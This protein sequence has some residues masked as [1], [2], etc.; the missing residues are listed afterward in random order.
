MR[1]NSG[2]QMQYRLCLVVV[3]CVVGILWPCRRLWACDLCALYTAMQVESPQSGTFRASASEQYTFLDKLQRN[4]SYVQNQA[5]EYLKS[6]VTQVAA[7]Y[8]FS[9]SLAL[10]Y[11]LPVISRSF[12]RLKDGS[13]TSGSE[14][15]VGDMSFLLH[16]LPVRYSDGEIT[17]RVRLFAGLKL[18]TGDTS[19][20]G[21]ESHHSMSSTEMS[22][23]SSMASNTRP[24]HSESG[25]G[26]SDHEM[27]THDDEMT[28]SGIHSHDLTLG[29]GSWDFPLG[30][31]ITTQYK[32]FMAMADVQYMIRSEGAYSYRHANDLI[33]STAVGGFLYLDDSLQIAS[34]ARL[35]GQYKNNDRGAGGVEHDGSA[36]NGVFLGPEVSISSSK[37]I[38]AVVAL[39]LPVNTHNS[40]LQITPSYR[41]RGAITYRF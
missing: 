21:E 37:R 33:W 2:N 14:S 32:R 19:R 4:G 30:F 36:F 8:D 3:F 23:H 29:T 11:V 16:Y 24:Y 31:G 1:G 39:D 26:D 9:D 27:P 35:S 6:S 17:A 15:G 10:Q 41:W 7:Q 38:Q 12:R 13:V 22:S 5:D 34:R 18:P 40:G 20:L 28:E 25:H